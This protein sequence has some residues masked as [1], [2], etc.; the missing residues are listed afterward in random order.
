MAVIALTH[1]VDEPVQFLA[2]VREILA[3]GRDFFLVESRRIP[4]AD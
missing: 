3:K 1:G 4:A 2:E